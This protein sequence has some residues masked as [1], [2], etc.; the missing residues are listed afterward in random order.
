M[1]E[2]SVIVH[3]CQP[4]KT[5]LTEAFLHLTKCTVTFR[6]DIIYIMSQENIATALVVSLVLGEDLWNV[7]M[8]Y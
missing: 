3:I 1:T 8:I 6:E 2:L 4:W 7:L 5:V